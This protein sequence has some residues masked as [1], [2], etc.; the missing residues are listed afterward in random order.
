[1]S[2][3]ASQEVQSLVAEFADRLHAKRS[4]S[5]C[6]TI[7]AESV[8]D[9]LKDVVFQTDAEG[10]WSFLNPAWT[11]LSGHPVDES[12][13]ECFLDYVYPADRDL[14]AERFRPLIAREKDYCRHEI[15]YLH[16]NGTYRWVEVFARLTLNEQDE[17]IGTSG[18]LRDI[19]ELKANEEKLR[20]AASVF[21]HAGEGI[22]ITDDMGLIVDVN[23]AFE[24]ITGYKREEALGQNPR[25][26]SSGR[27]GKEFYST[28]WASLRTNDFWQGEVWNRRKTGEL[29][30]ERLT[31]T[32]VRDEKRAQR[33]FVGIF[34]DITTQTLQAQHLEKIAHYDP[35]TGLPNRRLLSSR[36]AQS[37]A[38]ARRHRTRVAVCYMDLDGFKAVNDEYGHEYGDE[39]LIS[40]GKR[41]KHAVRECDTICR[42]GGDEFL[43][44]LDQVAD[45]ADCL[46]FV[47][48]IMDAV[49][50]PVNVRDVPLKVTC[51]LGI[52]LYPQDTEIDPDQLIRQA[53]QAMYSAKTHGK[54]RYV[55]FDSAG[56]T[57]VE[58]GDGELD[59]DVRAMA[60][61]LKEGEFELYYQPIITLAT[62]ELN[63]VEALIRWNHPELGLLLPG[64]F[65]PKVEGEPL[66]LLIEDWV[67]HEA[68][69]QHERWLDQGL[70][71]PISVNMSGAQL[72]QPD[73]LEKLKLKLKAHPRV[74]PNRIKLEVLETSALEDIHHVSRTIIECAK[75]GVGFALDD[76]GTGY[77][78][79]LY[80]KQL[81]AD[82]IKIDQRFVKN[83]LADPDD[84]AILEGIIGMAGAFKRE[85]I[86]EGVESFAHARMLIQIG[87]SMAQGF[88]IARPMPALQLR[89]WVDTWKMPEFLLQ[90]A[91]TDRAGL[92]LLAAAVEH[93]GWVARLVGYLQSESVPEP[94]AQHQTCCVDNWL[95][96]NSVRFATNPQPLTA[97]R[98][99]H[100]E[101]HQTAHLLLS[102]NVERPTSAHAQ[103]IQR[104][105][106]LGERLFET[107]SELID[108][109]AHARQPL[110]TEQCHQC[111]CSHTAIGDMGDDGK[112]N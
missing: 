104:L 83:M 31:I 52:S 103:G 34:S 41:L 9:N 11:E 10:R 77:S 75:L 50:L 65:L 86:A 62:G 87:C 70:D 64:T 53:D 14:N 68:I 56:A 7:V 80:L 85:T 46:P 95:R 81:P 44:V 94:V 21:S 108:T 43:A 79:L 4:S 101:L 8:L 99:L 107:I 35:L 111:S 27:Q 32:A 28:M 39:L 42:L 110:P 37:M 17:V 49:A 90:C 61:A 100:A 92:Q 63:S 105:E 69:A 47:N 29:Y 24:A 1:M 2:A 72:Q 57:S 6:R 15:R 20:F 112:V 78:S 82:R 16:K 98:D 106:N 97:I 58:F 18:T 30:V 5:D 19:T 12:I 74:N 3:N 76:F 40:I 45:V 91:P 67:L 25:M 38:Q 96:E 66:A 102:N 60:D 23:R 33:H 13:G 51:S 26:L 54:N 88:G 59:A 73:F 84:L 93:R 109:F 48:R 36:L 55:L 71:L 89:N 22:I